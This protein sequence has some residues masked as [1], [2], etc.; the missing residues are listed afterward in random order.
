MKITKRPEAGSANLVMYA[1]FS[2]YDRKLN[3][4]ATTSAAG[5]L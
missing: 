1:L 2:M 5:A 3:A 4:E